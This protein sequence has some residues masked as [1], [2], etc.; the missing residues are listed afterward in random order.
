MKKVT[1]EL[2]YWVICNEWYRSCSNDG[3]TKSK[4]IALAKKW[5]ESPNNNKYRVIEKDGRK[6]T[7]IYPKP[8]G[9]K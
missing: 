7:V 6:T 4:L 8:R 1:H 9:R 2:Q 3:H 5:N